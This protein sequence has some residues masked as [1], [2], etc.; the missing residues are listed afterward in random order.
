MYRTPVSTDDG[1]Q[2][3]MVPPAPIPAAPSP[4][5]DRDHDQE[6]DLTA[7]ERAFLTYLA[8]RAVAHLIR[9]D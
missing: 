4:G 1:R 3:G 8:E 7:E 6:T 5:S 2:P 9:D